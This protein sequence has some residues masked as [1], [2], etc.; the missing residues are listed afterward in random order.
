MWKYIYKSLLLYKWNLR[1]YRKHVEH[2]RSFSF[3]APPRR[4]PAH[5]FRLV[6]LFF[7][8]FFLYYSFSF[9]NAQM[10]RIFLGWCTKVPPDV[11][12]YHVSWFY[13]S[14]VPSHKYRYRRL[15]KFQINI[16]VIINNQTPILRC[17]LG[18]DARGVMP[19]I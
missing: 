16:W 1:T 14:G 8:F 10:V 9:S 7:Y 6:I 5:I 11:S 17:M 12:A 4:I 15:I 13:F 19:D 18:D 3:H 2:A